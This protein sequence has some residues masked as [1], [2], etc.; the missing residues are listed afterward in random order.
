VTRSQLIT[1]LTLVTIICLGSAVLLL[2]QR[3]GA[4][5]EQVR[6]VP[7]QPSEVREVVVEPVDGPAQRLLRAGAEGWEIE[8]PPTREGEPTTGAGAAPVRWPA[9]TDRVHGFLR[10]LDRLRG[11]PAPA[12]AAA[13]PELRARISSDD[14]RTTTIG[15]PATP[16][17]GR[18][19]VHVEDGGGD[20]RSLV[21]TD[22]LN[23]L[24][25]GPGLAGWLDSRV[26][27]G[28][29]GQPIEIAIASG[30]SEMRLSRAG[31]GWRLS[32]PFAAPA[33]AA[34]VE[35]LVRGLQMLPFIARTAPP[36][37]D[38]ADGLPA[39]TITL[40]A[41][42]R[43]PGTDGEIVSEQTAHSLRTLGAPDPGGAI[44]AKI[45]AARVAPQASGT[46]PTAG[47][48]TVE[49][50]GARLTA[51]VRQPEF[52]LSRRTL[53]AT[54]GDIHA[55]AVAYP[56]G[57]DQRWERAGQGWTAPGG[58]VPPAGAAALDGL[59]AL[60]T[61]ATAPVAAWVGEEDAPQTSEVAAIRCLGF[62]GAE[63]TSVRLAVGPLPGPGAD[64]RQH[65]IVTT[66]G[67]AR[68]YA[69]EA[70]VDAL[71]WIVD[72]AE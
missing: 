2:P 16:L 11:V 53:D 56:D 68:Y 69:P 15:L 21:T 4:A 43:R 59:A 39:T 6:L 47:P 48:L 17:G 23:R 1:L 67:I 49:I 42:V 27:A 60:F 34:L 45:E 19:V 61:E 20:P 41:E 35:E 22:E 10:I 57:R 26:F 31:G 52:Y 40:L 64:A 13:A 9:A 72:A 33:E 29:K 55:F 62:G 3:E 50:D 58:P 5:V 46:P 12:D 66:A 36:S 44:A 18:A 54:P 37:P 24:L 14:G 32:A 8:L 65:A 30:G 25:G 38:A 7:F 51:L 71:R 28:V 63:L 70:A